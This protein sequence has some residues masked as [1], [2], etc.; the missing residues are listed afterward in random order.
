MKGNGLDT[1][2]L[3]GVISALEDV[4]DKW[5]NQRNFLK[6]PDLRDAI[7]YLKEYR[8]RQENLDQFETYHF[9]QH[10]PLT[11]DELQQMEGKPVWIELGLLRPRWYLIEGFNGDQMIG[12]DALSVRVPFYKD[13]IYTGGWQA[14]RKERE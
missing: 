10:R 7:M 11:W 4:R 12:V 3:G 6:Y 9:E 8:E 5:Q 2:T 14:Y 13:G 1:D